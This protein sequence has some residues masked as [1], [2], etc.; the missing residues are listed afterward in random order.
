MRRIAIRT[1][2]APVGGDYL[3]RG[4]YLHYTVQLVEERY[5]F[6]AREVLDK[7]GAAHPIDRVIGIR[8]AFTDIVDNL[9]SKI[10]GI[11]ANPALWCVL[12]TA[13]IKPYFFRYSF[14][15]I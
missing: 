1:R 15:N 9:L 2:M 4:S 11:N 7:M 10:Y 3:C 14:W 8:Q 6:C 12:P 13:N 5:P